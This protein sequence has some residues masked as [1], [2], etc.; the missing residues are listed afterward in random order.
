MCSRCGLV[1]TDQITEELELKKNM[2]VDVQP[3][4]PQKAKKK[5]IT[6]TTK[7]SAIKTRQQL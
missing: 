1:K 7:R 6:K 4:L 2:R 3:R 5:K